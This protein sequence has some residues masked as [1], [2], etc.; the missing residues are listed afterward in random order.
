MTIPLGF[1]EPLFIKII[2]LKT[3][4]VV[5]LHILAQSMHGLDLL[6]PTS[7]EI[8]RDLVDLPSFLSTTVEGWVSSNISH[9]GTELSVSFFS[10]YDSK[11]SAI[12]CFYCWCFYSFFP[13]ILLQN[14]L[15]RPCLIL[16]LI[17]MLCGYL[18]KLNMQVF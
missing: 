7:Q 8:T 14:L 9:F 1:Q 17:Q 2:H 15:A 6:L 16:P 13:F 12:P 11:L 4:R 3:L 10:I 5:P 18:H